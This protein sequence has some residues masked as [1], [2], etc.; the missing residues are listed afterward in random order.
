MHEQD[1]ILEMA[2][3]VVSMI[4]MG[5][6][7]IWGAYSVLNAYYDVPEERSA[8]TN[9]MT[10]WEPTP[11]IPKSA[12]EMYV[13]LV[14]NDAF[15]PDPTHVQFLYGPIRYDINFNQAWFTDKEVGIKKA[16]DEFFCDK[17]D[18]YV[19]S[20]EINPAHTVWTITL[21]K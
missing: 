10:T 11:E 1:D 3:A 18:T 7:T 19:K 12:E 15:C 13:A 17:M 2:V 6:I 8:L 14:V 20:I 9:T 21:T 4:L 16:W 5:I